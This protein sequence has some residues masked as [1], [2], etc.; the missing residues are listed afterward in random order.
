MQQMV[1]DTEPPGSILSIEKKHSVVF[2][3][4]SQ[5]TPEE[6]TWLAVKYSTLFIG[7]S[8]PFS[9]FVVLSWSGWMAHTVGVF[10]E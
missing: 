6:I 5:A 8:L 3:F 1:C 9:E 10:T 2:S 7:L 4:L